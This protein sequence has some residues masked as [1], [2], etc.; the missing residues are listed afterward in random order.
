MY[1]HN[2]GIPSNLLICLYFVPVFTEML[3]YT[4]LEV[5][6]KGIYLNLLYLTACLIPI[7]TATYCIYRNYPKCICYCGM[8]FSC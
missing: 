6:S 5:T 2:V 7:L 4:H 3:V 8:L 1:E